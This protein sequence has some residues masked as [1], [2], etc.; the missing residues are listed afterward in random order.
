MSSYSYERELILGPGEGIKFQEKEVELLGISNSMGSNYISKK[1]NIRV[2]T[3]KGGFDLISEKRTYIPSGQV[4]T[5]AG[6]E[7]GIFRDFYVSIGDNL[8]GDS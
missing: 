3:N 4:T 8:E 1:A 5:E 6:I 2:S 7:A